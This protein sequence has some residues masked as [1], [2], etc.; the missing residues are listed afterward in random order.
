MIRTSSAIGGGGTAGAALLR[1]AGVAALGAASGVLAKVA[2]ESGIGWLS[3]LGSYPGAWV[4]VVALFGFLAPTPMAAGL[5][6]ALFFVAMCLAY[7]GWSILALGFPFASELFFWLAIAVSA[8]PA[9]AASAWW[10]TRH[11]GFRAG[12][13]LAAIAG[14]A[15]SSGRAH[16][17]WLYANGLVPEH[18]LRPVQALLEISMALVIALVL[19]RYGVTRGWAAAALV[20]MVWIAPRLVELAERALRAAAHGLT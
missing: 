10:A 13:V 17:F 2:D 6:S 19:P 14:L 4:V 16:Q 11:R 18:V 12:V 9:I 20:P 1:L 15:L 7:Y 5:R 3:D 8:V